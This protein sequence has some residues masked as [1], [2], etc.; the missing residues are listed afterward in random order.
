M[1]NKLRGLVLVG[2]LA[3]APAAFAIPFTIQIDNNFLGV[4]GGDWTLK[5]PGTDTGGE[6]ALLPLGSFSA[7]RNIG[8]GTYDWSILGK[9]YLTDVS[10]RILVNNIQRDS[11]SA[12]GYNIFKKFDITDSGEVVVR[13]VPEPGTLA[14]LGLGLLGIGF[15]VRR[16]QP[17]A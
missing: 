17:E 16:R 12:S 4:A 8:P 7:S 3:L 15:S 2:C 9:G 13:A 1:I 5:G 14:L 6:F 11:G 10:W